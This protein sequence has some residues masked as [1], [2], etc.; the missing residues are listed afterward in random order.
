MGIV[1]RHH[2]TPSQVLCPYPE[3]TEVCSVMHYT[4][5][6]YIRR[7]AFKAVADIIYKAHYICFI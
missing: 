3:A 7:V 2:R 6:F 1:A 5:L 4:D